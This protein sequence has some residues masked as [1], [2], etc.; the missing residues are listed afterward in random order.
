ML[1]GILLPSNMAA[2]TERV[3]CRF[4][5]AGRRL[6]VAGC[7]SE[8]GVRTNG[9][10]SLVPRNCFLGVGICIRSPVDQ[11]FSASHF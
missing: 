5:V 9:Q 7:R 6:Q 3:I 8:F 10:I 4:Q 2:K 11:N 1:E